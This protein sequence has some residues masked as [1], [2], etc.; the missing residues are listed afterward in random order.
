MLLDRYQG[1]DADPEAIRQINF[2]GNLDWPGNTT[3]F[4]VTDKAKATIFD[5]SEG[6]VRLLYIYFDLI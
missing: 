2:I 1:L 4:V 6:T 5:F 3:M